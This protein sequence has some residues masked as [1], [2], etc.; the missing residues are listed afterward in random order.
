M[1]VEKCLYTLKEPTNTKRKNA[2]ATGDD[3][4]RVAG[5]RLATSRNSRCLQNTSGG[6][7]A[8][9]TTSDANYMEKG[10]QPSFDHP[11]TSRPEW[12]LIG[13][14]N[15]QQETEVV[16]A[17]KCWN[18]TTQDQL[19]WNYREKEQNPTCTAQHANKLKDNLQRKNQTHTCTSARC[20]LDP[21]RGS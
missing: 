18:R 8:S 6:R 2:A 16:P 5:S 19:Y 7:G 20:T 1:S 10:E 11:T 3:T 13:K 21:A 17:R 4:S 9:H 12:G 14:T 15:P